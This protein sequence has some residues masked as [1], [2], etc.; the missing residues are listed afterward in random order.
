MRWQK[1]VRALMIN[2]DIILSGLIWVKQGFQ[3]K[4]AAAE[5]LPVNLSSTAGYFLIC[6]E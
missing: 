1:S 6:L 5:V 4:P 2:R 3:N